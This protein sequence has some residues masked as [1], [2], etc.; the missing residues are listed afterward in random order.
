MIGGVPGLVAL[1]GHSLR[2][3]L[4][5]PLEPAAIRA[6]VSGMVATTVAPL[7]LLRGRRDH[8]FGG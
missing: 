8:L 1:A 5:V 2:A 4:D 6:S 3:G 7:A